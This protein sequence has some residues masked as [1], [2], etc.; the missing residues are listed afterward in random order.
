MMAI[1]GL[2]SQVDQIQEAIKKGDPTEIAVRFV[3]MACM[4]F[5][6]TSQ[7]FTGDTLVAVENGL[8]LIEEIE[9]GDYVWS[10]NT[11]NGKR[12]LKEVIGISVTMTDVLVYV[13]TGDGEVIR[14]TENHPFYTEEKGWCAAAELEDG[15]ILHTRDGKTEVVAEVVVEKQD[16][17][18]KVYN[19]TIEDNHTYY[20]S[21]VEVLVHNIC[22]NQEMNQ[23]KEDILEGKDTT[24]RSLD[25]LLL[26]IQKKFPDLLQEEAGHRS[27]EG[28]HFDKHEIEK[29]NNEILE[30]INI[31]SK[32]YGFRV[33]LFWEE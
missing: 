8:I 5:G 17:P 1:F 20:V 19:L 23:K 9:I 21:E 13:T 30:H 2:S 6:L 33:H 7:C 28:W 15:D 31:Y 14:T 11:E 32:K 4:L 29:Y 18:V 22:N 25:D 16:N 3:Q 24:F 27:A 26:F 12:E 10:E